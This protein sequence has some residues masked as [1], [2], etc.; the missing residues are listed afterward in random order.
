MQWNIDSSHT[1]LDMSVRHMG[2][3]TVRGSFDQVA[4]TVETDA[5]G[6]LTSVEATVEAASINTRDANRDAHLRSAD[7]LDA[8]QYPNLIF[9]ST[10]IESVGGNRYQVTG[11][12]TIRDQTHLITLEVE[13]S[14]PITDPWGLVRAGATAT[15]KLSRK[16]WGLTWNQVL[17]TGSLLVGDEIKFSVDVQVVAAAPSTAQVAEAVGQTA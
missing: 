5:D 4:G 15:G 16:Q 10:Q 3:F 13:T 2:P 9:R 12:F 11:D 7:F 6:K 14:E 8:E 17:E 1:S